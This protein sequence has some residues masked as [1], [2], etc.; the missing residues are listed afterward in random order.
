VTRAGRL[1]L[2]AVGLGGLL[3]L[4]AAAAAG[5][6]DFGSVSS[7][8]AAFARHAAYVDRHAANSVAAVV[9]D[10]RGLDTMIEE[11]ILFAA[12]S[13][14]ALLLRSSRAED[15]E[16]A[17]DSGEGDA[18]TLFGIAGVGAV[19]VLGLY[20]VAHGY[21]TPGGGFQGGVVLASAAGLVFLGGTYRAFRRV[22][23]QRVVEAA[24]SAGVLVWPALGI[25]VLASGGA[26]L[27]NVLPRGSLGSLASAGTIPLLNAATGLA[28]AAAFTLIGVEFLEE[29]FAERARGEAGGT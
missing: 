20:V 29:L 21:L 3:A 19:V 6:P 2:L 16:R 17:E 9:F 24:E 26:F 11:S 8:Y 4:L 18:L 22:T 1:A 15:A 28:V 10:V 27:G 5:L 14:T 12:A 7:V 23:P 25:G 13:A